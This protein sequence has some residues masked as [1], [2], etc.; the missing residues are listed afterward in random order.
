MFC[1]N[2]PQD[3]SS[4]PVPRVRFMEAAG[5]GVELFA[6]PHGESGEPHPSPIPFQVEPLI[7]IFS[8]FLFVLFCWCC[9]QIESLLS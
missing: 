3:L 4:E 6:M 2:V 7:Y 1:Y 8:P 9:L 5:E